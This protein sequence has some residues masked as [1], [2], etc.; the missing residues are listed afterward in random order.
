MLRAFRKTHSDPF[1]TVTDTSGGC[2]SPV[3]KTAIP[4]RNTLRTTLCS[5]NLCTRRRSPKGASEESRCLC[6]VLILYLLVPRE[7]EEVLYLSF[8]PSFGIFAP[9]LCT[10][11]LAYGRTTSLPL[12]LC[13]ISLQES[14]LL[15][16]SE[17]L[18]NLL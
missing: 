4:P 5:M 17:S 2:G 6:L 18:F 11:H 1:A 7:K 15:F 12:H 3:L 16:S 13:V 14:T 8:L 10:V 9:R